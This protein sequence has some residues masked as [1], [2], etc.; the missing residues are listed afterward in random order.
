M[1]NRRKITTLAAALAAVMLAGMLAMLV[2]FCGPIIR[3]VGAYEPY[4][5]IMRENPILT[6]AEPNRQVRIM[7]ENVGIKQNSEPISEDIFLGEATPIKLGKEDLRER[8]RREC[9]GADLE[10]AS[11]QVMWEQGGALRPLE[12]LA[13]QRPKSDTSYRLLAVLDRGGI[14]IPA[15]IEYRVRVC[16]GALEVAARDGEL[17][18][19]QGGG[20]TLY[21]RAEDGAAKFTGLPYGRY[22]VT[23]MSS[24]ESRSCLLGLCEESWARR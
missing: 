1:L 5:Q 21:S 8:V 3:A 4:E 24:E 22:T 15:Q 16:S 2:A 11:L 23:A 20:M 10:G 17:F 13:A 19:L 6:A 18:Q 12:D 9:F 14:R 7:R